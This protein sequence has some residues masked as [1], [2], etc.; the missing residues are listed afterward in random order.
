MHNTLLLVLVVVTALSFDFTNGFHDTANAMATSIATGALRPRIAVALCGVLNFVGAF[1]S[2]KVAATIASGIVDQNVVTLP[3]VFAGLL[4]GIAWNVL[5]W[6]FGLPSSSSHA[7]IGGVIGATAVAAGTSAV[8]GQSIVSKVVI[9]AVLSPIIAG[10]VAAIATFVAYRIARPNQVRETRKT[11]RL[12]QIASASLVSLAHGTNDAQK[13][14]G[15]ITLA[16]I[17]DAR[18]DKGSDPPTWVIASCALAIAAG[19]YLGGWRVIRT[20]GHRL[21][22]VESPQGFAAETSAAAVLLIAT[23]N[24]LPLSTTHITAGAVMGSGMGKAADVKWRIAGRMVVAWIVTLPAAAAVAAGIAFATKRGGN[25]SIVIVAVLAVAVLAGVYAISRRDPVGA[26]N[27]N[28][29]AVDEGALA[30]RST[31]ASAKATVGSV[32]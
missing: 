29:E 23:R 15:I 19:T 10:L 31:P 17:A 9:P 13:T 30:G 6:Y 26:H 1:L 4:G 2:I 27:I 12:G 20:M 8:K 11:F 14:M 28:D 32:T 18:L 5:T 22:Q 7:L 25:T 3:I 21:T 16:L 24:G